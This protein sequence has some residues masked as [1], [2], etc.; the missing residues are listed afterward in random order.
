MTRTDPTAVT[1]A[2]SAHTP[3]IRA[4]ASIRIPGVDQP[5]W[6]VGIYP[7]SCRR[8]APLLPHCFPGH[9]QRLGGE[10][11]VTG[12]N[13]GKVRVW[14]ASG[15]RAPVGVEQPSG[16]NV[17]GGPLFLSLPCAET[18]FHGVVSG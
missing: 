8:M 12:C 13:D 1:T 16:N 9:G 5:T 15:M 4:P 14:P 2:P 17:N 10:Y 3:T 18:V 11:L 7:R 6:S